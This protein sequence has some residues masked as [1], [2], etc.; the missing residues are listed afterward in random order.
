LVLPKSSWLVENP[1]SS[2]DDSESRK[3]DT[4]EKPAKPAAKNKASANK[5][6]TQVREKTEPTKG[7]LN[8]PHKRRIETRVDEEEQEEAE[9]VTQGEEPTSK[10]ARTRVN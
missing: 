7:K 4:R 10:R 9:E 1:E 8:H 3:A 2:T 6:K 5:G